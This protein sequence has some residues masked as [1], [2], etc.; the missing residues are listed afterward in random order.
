[1]TDEVVAVCDVGTAA[2]PGT[3]ICTDAAGGIYRFNSLTNTESEQSAIA[4]TRLPVSNQVRVFATIT[5]GAPKRVLNA[6]S[7]EGTEESIGMP[8]AVPSKSEKQLEHDESIVASDLEES[9][10][11]LK[12]IEHSLEQTYRTA[13]QLEE[14]VAR[15]KQV[16]ALQEARLKQAELRQKPN[17]K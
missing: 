6:D 4:T 14:S 2:N 8:A 1:M 15:L 11:A 10:R 5:P 9:M 7:K 16:I 12:S 3:L 17:R 13:E